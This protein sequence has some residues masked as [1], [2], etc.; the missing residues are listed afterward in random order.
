[1][2]YKVCENVLGAVGGTPLVEIPRYRWPGGPRLYVKLEQTNPTGSAKDRAA[3]SMIEATE[4]EANLRPGANLVVATSGN[5]GM[6]MS[7]ICARKQFRLWCVV[8][9]KISPCVERML[10]VYGTEIVKVSEGEVDERGGYHGSRLKRVKELV[11]EL[12]NAHYI[13]QYDNRWNVEA[14]Y[15]STGPEIA[16]AFGGNLAAVIVAAGTGG[17]SMG[18]ARY[19][20]EHHPNTDV[21]LVDEVGSVALPKN[22]G[23]APRHLNGMGTSIEPANYD[24]PNFDDFVT[25]TRFITADQAISASVELARTE[26]ILPGGTGGAVLHVMRNQARSCYGPEDR[27]VGLLPDSG[28]KYAETQF[29][30]EWLAERGIRVPLLESN[31]DDVEQRQAS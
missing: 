28:L 24:R 27:I 23:E 3:L 26:G 8:D 4:R 19:F 17:T 15:R 7:M 2:S 21:W 9:P 14:H 25:H 22:P 1:M 20:R 11:A 18:V 5:M 6:A 29:N 12:G 10:R 31:E 16:S 13:D 30:P